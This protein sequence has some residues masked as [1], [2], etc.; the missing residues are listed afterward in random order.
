MTHI[1]SNQARSGVSAAQQQTLS[2]SIAMSTR[3]LFL[4]KKE[5]P[6]PISRLALF[7]LSGVTTTRSPGKPIPP[8][9]QNQQTYP[10]FPRSNGP[11][12]GTNFHKHD[13]FKA[14]TT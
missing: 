3:L 14:I 4:Q 2:Y 7:Q 12:P 11:L 13:T 10:L 9:A 1:S 8:C 5:V 6:E